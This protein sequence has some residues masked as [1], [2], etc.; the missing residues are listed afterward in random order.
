MR[1][2]GPGHRRL[3]VRGWRPDPYGVRASDRRLERLTGRTAGR[4]FGSRKPAGFLPRGST[5][6]PLRR[7]S[8]LRTVERSLFSNRSTR[9]G[10]G[11]CAQKNSGEV[12]THWL[13]QL[14]IG[15]RA[16]VAV[17]PPAAELRGVTEAD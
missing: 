6:G 1:G 3:A 16:W 12:V 8:Q 9:L 7:G 14:R 11:G 5:P 15:A 4:R 17:W 10:S 2:P 13:V